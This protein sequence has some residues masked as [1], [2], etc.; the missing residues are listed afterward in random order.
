MRD[1]IQWPTLAPNPSYTK[2]GENDVRYT[3]GLPSLALTIALIVSLFAAVVPTVAYSIAFYWADRYEREPRSLIVIAFVWGAIP[4]ILLSLLGELALGTPFVSN[5]ESLE[6]ALVAGVVVAPIVEEIMKSAALLGLYM[7]KRNE[8]DGVLDGLIYGALVGF[9]FAMTE[10]FLYFIGAYQDGGFSGLSLVIVIRAIIFGLNH[11]F[12]TGLI[13]IGFG[14][15]RNEPRRLVRLVWIAL[16]LGAAIIVHA[17]HNL[18]VT[19]AGVNPL[20][21]LLSLMIAAGGLSLVVAAVIM[22]WNHE[23]SVIRMELAEEL[24]NIL[25]AQELIELTGHWRHPMRTRAAD[26]SDRMALYVELAVRKR[27]L[28]TLGTAVSPNLADEIEEIRKQL[29]QMSEE[30]Q[31]ITTQS[32][33]DEASNSAM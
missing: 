15:A 12:Y 26:R 18:G 30:A 19:V 16:G 17:L 9:G 8:F 4:A 2:P 6:A 3:E 29:K 27:R 32:A 14:L 11:A 5:A 21:F 13:G 24:G 25:T 28:R 33:A 10:N 7:W 22:A 31:I 23:R 20:G 1:R